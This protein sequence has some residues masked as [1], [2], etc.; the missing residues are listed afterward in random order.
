LFVGAVGMLAYAIVLI[1]EFLQNPSSP[2]LLVLAALPGLISAAGFRCA[3][4]GAITDDQG[5]TIRNPRHTCRLGWEEI[6]HFS[7]E[8]GGFTWGTA[9][10]HLRNG[11]EVRIWGIQKPNAMTRP[12][13]NDAEY[14]VSVLNS[15]LERARQREG[16]AG[17]A[18][19][20]AEHG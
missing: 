2:A 1:V 5:L 6:D 7:I 14:L 18:G 17:S 9:T 15:S 4:A 8:R 11:R 16:A 19:T 10:A 20:V 13:N 3:L 12:T